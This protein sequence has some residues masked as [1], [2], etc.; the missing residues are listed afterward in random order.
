MLSLQALS[1]SNVCTWREQPNPPPST[2]GQC[3]NRRLTLPYLRGPCDEGSKLGSR[4]CGNPSGCI[5]CQSPSRGT[6]ITCGRYPLAEEAMLFVLRL[7]SS[8]TLLVPFSSLLP[9]LLPHCARFLLSFLA[10]CNP[11]LIV[12]LSYCNSTISTARKPPRCVSALLY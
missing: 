6:T 2:S 8:F 10:T 12:L 7:S 9:L 11:L 5:T 1:D 4:P 3:A